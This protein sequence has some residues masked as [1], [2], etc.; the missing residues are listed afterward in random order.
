L[1]ELVETIDRAGTDPA[2]AGLVARV[3]GG[4]S[5]MARAQ[6]I[7][8]AVLRFRTHRK[9]AWAQ[10]ETFGEG[11]NATHGY[12][13]ASAFDRI[14]LQPS[15]DLWLSGVALETPFVK[16]MFE[17]LGVQPVF[18]KRYEYKNAVDFYTEK[19]FTPAHRE[20]L[21]KLK[22][23][24]F[25]QLVRGIA[26]GRRLPET[27]IR[28]AIDR[29]PLLGTEAVGARLIDELA[30]RDQ[31]VRQALSRAGRSAEMVSLVRYRA[32]IG[33]PRGRR[34][35][36]LIYGVGEVTR[37]RSAENPFVGSLTMGSESVGAAFRSAADDPAIR[38][39]VFR[40]DSPGGSYVASDTIWR[41]VA[42]ARE[43]GKPVV[44]SMGDVAGSGGYFVAIG[45]DKIVAQPGTIT[46]SIGVFA[47]KFVISGLLE[48]LGVSFDEVHS[49]SNALLWDPTRDFS[50]AE[51]ARFD[52]WLDRVY[53]DFTGKVAAGRRLSKERV[54]EIARGRIWSGEDALALKLVDELGGLETAVRLAKI[55]AKIPLSENVALE[56]FPRPR[57]LAEIVRSRM[58]GRREADRE[59]E[60][61]AQMIGGALRTLQPLARRLHEL[62]LDGPR[63]VLSMPEVR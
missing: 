34:A 56:V 26:S 40:V 16:G 27:D 38:A 32:R 44:V 54:H 33:R 35:I 39:I 21:E 49:G 19:G 30:Y 55:S 8:D 14:F 45:A 7:R 5:G 37:G 10:A 52:A 48:K 13:L 6:E 53:E 61:D 36:A 63:G 50:P 1:R 11:G 58:F 41:E 51:R 24:W 31:V 57:T 59:D 23:S 29:A 17:K 18:G 25:G 15:G 46:G 12:F 28:A 47:G 3:G 20:A 22:D 62:G 60:G 9:F 2:V 4:P 42:R 43:K